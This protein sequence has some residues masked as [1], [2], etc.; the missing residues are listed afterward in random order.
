ME[1][2]KE[3]TVYYFEINARLENQEVSIDSL[4]SNLISHKITNSDYYYR[5][6]LTGHTILIK[7]DENSKGFINGF[8]SYIRQ[9]NLPGI[10]DIDTGDLSGL[11]LEDSSALVDSA[12]FVI[13]GNY[14][15]M[16]YNRDAPRVNTIAPY[17]QHH[18]PDKVNYLVFQP[19][20]RED[21]SKVINNLLSLSSFEY[22][23]ISKAYS[24]AEDINK[25]D[26]DAIKWPSY[27]RFTNSKKLVFSKKHQKEDAAQ[28]FKKN[29]TINM[30][31]VYDD[32]I[33]NGKATEE[34]LK[35]W[36]LKEHKERDTIKLPLISEKSGMVKSQEAYSKLKELLEKRGFTKQ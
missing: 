11:D 10:I 31:D 27:S 36:S 29:F 14:M 2:E 13:H 16:E 8:I 1:K 19:I 17:M 34:N 32:I 26:L 28:K 15:A 7:A 30:L 21:P 12:H 25:D 23:Q 33:L 3:R 6:Q 5:L 24:F 22:V 35:N 18:F 4:F 9:D 20:M